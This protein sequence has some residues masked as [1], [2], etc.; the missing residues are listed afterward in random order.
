MR[1]YITASVMVILF[2][3]FTGNALAQAVPASSVPQNTNFFSW[4][5][6]SAIQSI[7]PDATPPAT[8]NA[9]GMYTGSS[10]SLTAQM[11]SSAGGLVVSEYIANQSV[12]GTIQLDVNGAAVGSAINVPKSASEWLSF[13]AVNVQSSDVVT[14]VTTTSWY[15]ASGNF[16]VLNVHG[17]LQ[18]WNTPDWSQ[19]GTTG[20]W[21]T[22]P[23]PSNIALDSTTGPLGLANQTEVPRQIQLQA[24]GVAWPDFSSYSSKTFYQP[25]STPIQPVKLCEW[26]STCVPNVS[27]TTDDLWRALMGLPNNA[28]SNRT[29]GTCATNCTWKGGGIPMTATVQPSPGTDGAAVVCLGGGDSGDPAWTLK[30]ADGSTFV[31][32]DGEQ[33]QGNCWEVWGLRADPTYNSSLPVS[34]TNTQW[35]VAYG[36]HRTGFIRTLGATENNTYGYS[37]DTFS[38]KYCPKTAAGE[39]KCNGVTD[40]VAQTWF[41][42]DVLQLGAAD[43]TT[44][45]YGWGV[46]AAETPLLTDVIQQND[47]QRILN[48]T[49][50]DF[51]H[52]IGIQLRYTRVVG[53]GYGGAWWPAGNSDGDNQ[54]VAPVE[55]MRLWWPSSVTMPSVLNLAAQSVYR[56]VAKY[57]LEIDD[58]SNGGTSI[59]YNA[60]GSVA[61]GGAL[62]IRYELG[63]S[64]SPCETLGWPDLSDLPWGQL[65]LIKQ[66]A[67]WGSDPT[68]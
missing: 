48:G 9:C 24:N 29:T 3:I 31:R 42:P 61:S 54:N 33:I 26:G 63:T 21:V 13:P 30:N 4:C 40:P 58:Q 41:G 57:G 28:T 6:K 23:I 16:K 64:T 2:F 20:N 19:L 32:P 59:T 36:A 18:P 38:G 55:G 35:E 51:G 43:S 46:T 65:K 17:E 25:L 44:Y 62:D 66:G 47:C 11:A 49:A 8:P 67:D 53:Y 14:V 68:S 5:S 34:I 15:R 52:A 7:Q 39:W 50:T 37:L 12:S 1:K 27:T 56:T 22:T 10:A 60:D 45:D